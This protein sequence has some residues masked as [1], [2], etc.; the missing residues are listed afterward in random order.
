MSIFDEQNKTKGGLIFL[1]HSHEDIHRVREIRNK[2]EKAGFEP[3]CFYLKCLSD[4]GEIEDLIKREIDAR[5]WF[6]FIDSDNS[7]KSKWVTRERAYITSTNSKKVITVDM[8]D[9]SSVDM[10]VNKMMHNL[11]IFISYSHADR[12]LECRIKIQLIKK[13]YLV[14]DDLALSVGCNWE[15]VMQK[16]ISEAS[17]NGCVLYLIT[18]NS[19]QLA[20]VRQEVLFALNKGGN[21]IPIICGEVELDKKLKFL[22]WNK[23]VFR[24]PAKATDADIEDLIEML[25][26]YII[27]C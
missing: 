23:P 15:P 2:L 19:I 22:L 13:D 10:A 27:S 12:D 26:Q 20:S 5:E 21:V 25:S 18:E 8:N 3:L 24:L 14:Y 9:E 7:R 16:M 6:L 17:R 4:D 1:S 11:R